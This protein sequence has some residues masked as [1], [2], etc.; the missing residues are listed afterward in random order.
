MVL[1]FAAHL[2]IDPSQVAMVGDSVHDLHAGRAAGA[3]AVAV[4]SGLADAET[5]APHADH[6]L[7][8]IRGLVGLQV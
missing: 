6:V 3:V 2:G 4:T 5:L 1:A 7:D 8:D